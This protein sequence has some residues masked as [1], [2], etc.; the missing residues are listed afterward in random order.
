[1]AFAHGD[2]RYPDGLTFALHDLCHLE[3]FVELEHHADQIGFFRIVERALAAPAMTAVERD[4]DDA[5]RADRDYVIADMNGSA[6]FLFA[7]L[8]MKLKL[9][10]LRRLHRDAVAPTLDVLLHAMAL[11][12]DI[13]AAA[14][15]VQPRRDHPADARRL[16]DYFESVTA[17]PPRSI[18]PAG[19]LSDAAP[20]AP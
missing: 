12:D 20:R 4:L 10:V 5:W 9:A 15:A 1:M 6:V 16:L 3:K 18:P 19:P 8:K 2:P 13:R 17:A 11:P 7:A 14:R